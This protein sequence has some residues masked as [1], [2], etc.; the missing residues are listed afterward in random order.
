V[1]GAD[2]RFHLANMPAGKYSLFSADES[3]T[4]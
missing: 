3:G 1:L 2:G 4:L